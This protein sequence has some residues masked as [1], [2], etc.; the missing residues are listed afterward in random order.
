M[1]FQNLPFLK[2]PNILAFSKAGTMTLLLILL[3][4]F[5]GI[6]SGLFGIGGGI[7]LV[8]TLVFLM[9]FDAQAAI[10]TSLVAMLL[11]VGALG[12][13]QYYQAGKITLE[14]MKSGGFIAAGLFVGAWLGARIAVNL[15][16]AVLQKGFSILLVVAA[17]R[18]WI[19]SR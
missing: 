8:P 1:K 17:V 19:Q 14:H 10:G 9:K 6:L 5:A 15:P 2:K 11:P 18:L 4:V 12:V 16:I 13:W 7:V 3:G